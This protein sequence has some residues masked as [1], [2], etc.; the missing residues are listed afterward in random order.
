MTVNLEL[1]PDVEET[2][3]A[4]ARVRGLSLAAY[5]QRLV[6]DSARGVSPPASNPPRFRL[7]L[8]RLAEMGRDLPHLPLSALSRESI[9][10]DRG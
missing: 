3:T 10:R 6:E 4:Q 2:L 8:D 1:K 5:L 9:Y 7:M